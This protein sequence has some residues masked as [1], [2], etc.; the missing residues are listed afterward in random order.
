MLRASWLA[1]LVIFTAYIS[2][3]I[4]LFRP[5]HHTPV[6][7]GVSYATAV[8]NP[9]TNLN[10][11]SREHQHH[12]SQ[13]TSQIECLLATAMQVIVG[14]PIFASGIKAVRNPRPSITP[15]LLCTKSR[16]NYHSSCVYNSLSKTSGQRCGDINPT[17]PHASLR[18]DS[19]GGPT[20]ILSFHS[21]PRPL[22]CTASLRCLQISSR[23]R[24]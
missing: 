18:C 16:G 15:R 11:S 17:L 12:S 4:P 1:S 3:F 13:L 24:R 5:L 19:T 6:M 20:W 10:T 8:H 21:P 9:A 14:A 2:P 22:L 7:R 23:T